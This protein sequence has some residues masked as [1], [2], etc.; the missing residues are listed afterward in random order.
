M[1]R[2]VT[3]SFAINGV[4]SYKEKPKLTV[5]ESH[6]KSHWKGYSFQLAIKV[7]NGYHYVK[8]FGG[9]VF[10]DQACT[11]L[12]NIEFAQDGNKV[13][14]SEAETRNSSI[15]DTIPSWK[16]TRFN[17]NEY[18][19]QGEFVKE[20]YDNIEALKDKKIFVSGQ[21]RFTYSKDKNTIYREFAVQ[22]ISLAQNQES[23]EFANGNIQ[24][25]FDNSS[26]DTSVFK[27]QA[28]DTKMIEEMGNRIPVRGY[29]VQYNSDAETRD[30][31]PNLFYPIDTYIRTDKLDF[32]DPK[33]VAILKLMLNQC[34]PTQANKIY[35]SAWKVS[36]KK[37]SSE[38]TLTEEEKK[39][40]LTREEIEYISLFPQMEEDF[41]KKKLQITSEKVN[42]VW[43][44]AP[45]PSFPI[46]EEVEDVSPDML[47]LYRTIGVYDSKAD[48]KKESKATTE[49]NSDINYDYFN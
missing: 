20:V 46:K 49:S 34:I 48:S 45:H 1:E 3:S 10:K 37:G 4:L 47:E 14:L 36:F 25:V 5:I 7:G 28:F 31:I 9:D 18:V 26:V 11:K 43:L 21:I 29:V 15:F 13:S 22:R 40:M 35:T 24:M 6:K 39:S 2:V 33:H 42:E 30:T 38:I 17:D 8:L 16:K 23:E 27:G 44:N 41:L 12:A 19:Y 32:E